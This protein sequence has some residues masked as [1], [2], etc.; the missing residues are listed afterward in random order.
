M[1]QRVFVGGQKEFRVVLQERLGGER[2][3]LPQLGD[4][5]RVAA[6][7]SKHVTETQVRFGEA[8]I[9]RDRTA[10]QRF[11]LP[12]LRAIGRDI[13]CGA[14]GSSADR[15]ALWMCGAANVSCTQPAKNRICASSG[16]SSAPR[17]K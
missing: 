3:R 2:E 11:G 4:R 13:E 15:T 16:K 10:K 9:G 12:Q 5:V 1:R 14:D 8:R 17:A 6:Q 7:A